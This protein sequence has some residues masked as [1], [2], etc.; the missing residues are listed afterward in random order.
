M[1]EQIAASNSHS[2]ISEKKMNEFEVAAQKEAIKHAI[3]KGLASYPEVNAAL[4]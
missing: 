2:S 1:E 3:I 4:I